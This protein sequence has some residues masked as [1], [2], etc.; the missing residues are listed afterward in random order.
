MLIYCFIYQ[1]LNKN[2]EM[3]ILL[4]FKRFNLTTKYFI[5]DMART[6]RPIFF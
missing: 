2:L 6:A 4:N 1:K 5:D 3:S